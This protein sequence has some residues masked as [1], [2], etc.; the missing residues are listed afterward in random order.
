MKELSIVLL[1][2]TVV[3]IEICLVRPEY[4]ASSCEITRTYPQAMIIT[5]VRMMISKRGITI[6][7]AAAPTAI[8]KKR[9]SLIS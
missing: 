8:P 1:I 3:V 2:V 9:N 5:T 7:R 6:T 4:S